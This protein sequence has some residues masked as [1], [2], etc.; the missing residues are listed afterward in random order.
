[1][2]LWDDLNWVDQVN[3][4]AQKPGKHFTLYWVFSKKDIGIQKFS[5]HAIGRSS[6]WLWD[7]CREGQTNASDRLQKEAAQ[8]TNHMQDSD[9]ET[10]AQSRVIECVCALFKA[11]FG[12]WAWKVIRRGCEGFTIWVGL[13]IFG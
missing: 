8:F 1:M 10:F 13:I 4:T 12:E 7:P 5:L 2:I 3:Y 9:W 11:Y 6:S